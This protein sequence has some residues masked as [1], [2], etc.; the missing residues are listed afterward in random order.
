MGMARTNPSSAALQLFLLMAYV[1]HSTL[2]EIRTYFSTY[3]A[4]SSITMN[5][6]VFGA[7]RHLNLQNALGLLTI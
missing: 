2:L 5:I 6:L 3:L 4:S 7:Y 1:P